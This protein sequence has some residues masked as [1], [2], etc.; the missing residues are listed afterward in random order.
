[1]TTPTIHILW[2][3]PHKEVFRASIGERWCYTCRKR[4]DFEYIRSVPIEPSYYEPVDQIEC[5]ECRT[6]DGDLFPGRAREWR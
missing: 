6:I 5:T 4:Q 2:T 1:M 3:E